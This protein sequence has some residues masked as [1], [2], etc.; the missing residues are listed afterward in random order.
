MP[1]MVSGGRADCLPTIT[2]CR[3]SNI[4]L[5][6]SVKGQECN[7]TKARLQ[8]AGQMYANHGV[9]FSGDGKQL[10]WPLAW[11]FSWR[12]PHGFSAA[13]LCTNS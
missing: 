2:V 13:G 4:G 10:H 8:A 7:I 6:V 12:W 3:A 11:R 1:L 5:Q 9:L